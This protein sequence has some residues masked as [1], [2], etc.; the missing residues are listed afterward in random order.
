MRIFDF[1]FQ[2]SMEAGDYHKSVF[3]I[4][5]NPETRSEVTIPKL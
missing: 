3:R 4:R 1:S 5:K 2:L